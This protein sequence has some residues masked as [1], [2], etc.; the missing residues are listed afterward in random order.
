MD[1]SSLCFSQNYTDSSLK[2]FSE[3]DFTDKSIEEIGLEQHDE[4]KKPE[5]L[6]TQRD[7]CYYSIKDI[8]ISGRC[9][10][11]GHAETCNAEDPNDPYKIQDHSI[12]QRGVPAG[13]QRVV[14][15]DYTAGDTPRHP[16]RTTIER[17]YLEHCPL[18]ATCCN[19]TWHDRET[20]HHLRYLLHTVNLNPLSRGHRH[21]LQSTLPRLLTPH[22]TLS[23]LF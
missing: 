15:A 17:N 23:T 12:Q 16:T 2:R 9:V 10:C 1:R 11:I 6:K 7:T 19:Y 21:R 20:P 4:T 5:N 3:V 22:L 8:S 14:R 13:K 18:S